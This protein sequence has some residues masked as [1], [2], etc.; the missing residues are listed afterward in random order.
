MQWRSVDRF[1]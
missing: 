1:V